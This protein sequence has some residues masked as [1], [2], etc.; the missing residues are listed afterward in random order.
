MRS[1][2]RNPCIGMCG[3]KFC[4]RT[5]LEPGQYIAMPHEIPVAFVYGADH[6]ILR[7]VPIQGDLPDLGNHPYR[8]TISTE[9]VDPAARLELSVNL[10]FQSPLKK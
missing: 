2:V 4:I 10:R 3:Q 8:V 5:T 9:P 7:E 1:A 6:T